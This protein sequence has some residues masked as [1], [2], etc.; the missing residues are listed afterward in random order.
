MYYGLRADRSRDGQGR[1]TIACIALAAFFFIPGLGFAAD[2]P[3]NEP[4]NAPL[5]QSVIPDLPDFEWVWQGPTAPLELLQA[6]PFGPE[7]KGGTYTDMGRG[8]PSRLTERETALLELSRLAVEASRLAG[9]LE[10]VVQETTT[11]MPADAERLKQEALGRAQTQTPVPGSGAPTD[12]MVPSTP[13]RTSGSVPL[14]QA[15]IEKLRAAREQ[16]ESGLVILP[17]AVPAAPNAAA[18]PPASGP[19]VAAPAEKT[20]SETTTSPRQTTPTTNGS[21]GEGK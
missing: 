14:T 6:A 13:G 12:H 11:P 16:A 8:A 3:I 4:S 7:D 5:D 10:A 18:I 1:S 21:N 9:T 19:A 17:S 20:A 2:E 15:E